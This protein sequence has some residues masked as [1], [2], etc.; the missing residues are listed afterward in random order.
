MK[1]IE[2]HVLPCSMECIVKRKSCEEK[3]CRHWINYEEDNNCSLIATSK[4]G[5]MTLQQIADRLE[6]SVV[7][8]CQI[9]KEVLR[10]VKKRLKNI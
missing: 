6:I 2:L 1:D 3:E 5:P 8:V 4:N 10:K 9:E 7:R